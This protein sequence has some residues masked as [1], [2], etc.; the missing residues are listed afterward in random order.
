MLSRLTPRGLRDSRCQLCRFQSIAIF[1]S[2][3]SRSLH[4][5][6]PES[7]EYINVPQVRQPDRIERPVIKG[8]LPT[9]RN[10]FTRR[11]PKRTTPKYF[12]LTTPEP[13]TPRAVISSPHKLYKL[14]LA[15]NRRQ[16][17]RE[18][19]KELR[20]RSQEET[21]HRKAISASNKIAREKAI[22]AA[23]R[24]DKRLTSPT[25][26]SA[27]QSLQVG[28]IPDPDRSERLAQKAAKVQ[29]LAAS[30]EEARRDAL[31]T[32]YMSARKFIT[33]EEQLNQV[34]EK[35]FIE[36]PFRT[37]NSMALARSIWAT[38]SP[39][40]VG[41]K[42]QKTRGGDVKAFSSKDRTSAVHAD[43]MKRIAEALTGGKM[44]GV[45]G[46]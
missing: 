4:H 42:L 17:L 44:D 31:H 40:T 13:S 5:I 38:G 46:T 6:R 37:A 29:A 10:L 35:Q 15:G 32:L 20:T 2:S 11:A 36:R 12:E 28:D 43:R 16:L 25:I 41:E 39:E 33:T 23:D 18:G 22:I 27:M 3:P 8:T 34:I 14:R 26:V 1:R 45:D 24:E 19:L 30:R 9:P 21:R 7:P